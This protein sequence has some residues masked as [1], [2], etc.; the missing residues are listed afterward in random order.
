MNMDVNDSKS[1]S[2]NFSG[3]SSGVYLV[4]IET[5]SDITSKRVAGQ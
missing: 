1:T 4:Q 5:S 2:L 3:L